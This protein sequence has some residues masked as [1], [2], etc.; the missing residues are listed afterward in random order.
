MVATKLIRGNHEST[1]TNDTLFPKLIEGIPLTTT[2]RPLQRWT[3][4]N[5]VVAAR[6]LM[7]ASDPTLK[8]QYL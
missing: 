2:D 7:C 1:R 3:N 5:Q 6:L 8:F 4:T